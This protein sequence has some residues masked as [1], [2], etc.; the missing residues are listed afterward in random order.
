VTDVD[1]ELYQ[2]QSLANALGHAWGAIKRTRIDSVLI[3]YVQSTFLKR[4]FRVNF[5]IRYVACSLALGENTV[6]SQKL[7]SNL[8]S[9]SHLHALELELQLS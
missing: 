6:P 3:G 1:V 9:Q 7:L 8:K 4:V 5:L 2:E